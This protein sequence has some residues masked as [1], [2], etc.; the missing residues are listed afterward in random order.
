M[1]WTIFFAALGAAFALYLGGL[2]LAW[3]HKRPARRR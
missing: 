1:A 3:R 2:W